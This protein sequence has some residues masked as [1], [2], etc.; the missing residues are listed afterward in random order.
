MINFEYTSNGDDTTNHNITKLIDS[1]WQI[2]V[3][4]TYLN[5]RVATQIYWTW[6]ISY[7]YTLSGSQVT[8]IL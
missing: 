4:N 8:K 3:T 6:T 2:Y 7:N 1:K 5:D